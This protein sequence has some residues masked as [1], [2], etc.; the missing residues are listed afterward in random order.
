MGVTV[1]ISTGQ[2]Q[3][4][5]NVHDQLT[6]SIS[7]GVTQTIDNLTLSQFSRLDYTI[8]FYND[9]ENIT[10]SM[11]LIVN[12]RGTTVTDQVFGR[13]GAMNVQVVASSTGTEYN[14]QI[15]NSE[16]FAVNYCLTVLT[17]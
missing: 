17:S 5:R 4:T 1:D 10:K 16:A 9:V 3:L 12:K 8:S 14:L 11:K 13:I 15:T 2:P 7:A 6:G